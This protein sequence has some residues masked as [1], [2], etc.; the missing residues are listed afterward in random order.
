MSIPI[1]PAPDLS[2]SYTV[3]TN[4][5]VAAIVGTI[6]SGGVLGVR[7]SALHSINSLVELVYIRIGNEVMGQALSKLEGALSATQRSLDALTTLQGLKNQ[8]SVG[9]KSGIPFNFT[10]KT[11]TITYTTTNTGGATIT[12]SKVLDDIDSYQSGYNI[13]ASAYYKPIDPY[14]AVSI[15]GGGAA[16]P[17][18]AKTS[19][20]M[21]SDTNMRNAYTYFRSSMMA[22]KAVISGLI[23]ALGPLTPQIN[24][25]PDPTSL[26][27]KLKSVY[28]HMPQDNYS[29]MRAWALDGYTAHGSSSVIKAG[30]LQQELTNAIVAGQSLNTSQQA[31]VRNYMF[32]FEQYYTSASSILSQ[33][34]QIMSSIARKLTQ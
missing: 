20:A 31:A 9:A 32:I 24:G 6:T 10:A 3:I 12:A 22:S 2:S 19:A 11:Q 7:T 4:A 27:A 29:S 5:D 16:V 23:S 8:I 25:Q 13:I 15:P 1:V 21:L 17:I 30:A 18:T 28:S 14:F 33:L 26:L 34:N